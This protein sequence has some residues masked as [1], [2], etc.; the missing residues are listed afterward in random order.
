MPEV[1]ATRA[2]SSWAYSV[3]PIPCNVVLALPGF[4]LQPWALRRKWAPRNSA[5]FLLGA[6]IRSIRSQRDPDGVTQRWWR[7]VT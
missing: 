3:A 4:N 6:A 5:T 2:R 1:L 7:L